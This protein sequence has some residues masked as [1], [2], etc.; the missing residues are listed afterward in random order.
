MD[1]EKKKAKLEGKSRDTLIDMI[2]DLNREIHKL[3]KDKD[4]YSELRKKYEDI[5]KNKEAK[6]AVNLE[7][8]KK[9]EAMSGNIQ[10]VT[11]SDYP[12]EK[13]DISEIQIMEKEDGAALIIVVMNANSSFNRMIFDLADMDE[14]VETE[15]EFKI[16]FYNKEELVL[17]KGQKKFFVFDPETEA[18]IQVDDEETY[19]KYLK[20]AE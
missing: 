11:D 13:K 15:E 6:K 7:V 16:T 17:A 10:T 4:Y 5:E 19:K 18:Y 2:L 8:L 14:I 20:S 12:S 3:V 1:F 9:I